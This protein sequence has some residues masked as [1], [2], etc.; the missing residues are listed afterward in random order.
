MTVTEL[1]ALMIKHG[2]V[3]RALPE[4]VCT[5]AEKYHADQFPNAEVQ[6]LPEYHREMLVEEKCLAH[7]G[8]YV[9]E[10]ARHSNAGVQFRGW[11]FFKSLNEVA[12]YLADL[13]EVQKND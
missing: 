6:F 13:E 9:L 2:A 1:E 3:I 5:V 4:S 7:G 10:L 11:R 8:Q 12:E